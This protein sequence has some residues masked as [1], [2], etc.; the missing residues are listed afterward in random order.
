M[1]RLIYGSSQYKWNFKVRMQKITDF[2]H[3]ELG[4]SMGLIKS[5]R[6][7]LY[8]L[9]FN[10]DFP[11]EEIKSLHN[12]DRIKAMQNCFEHNLNRKN[13]LQMF[14][15][16]VIRYLWFDCGVFAFK[17]SLDLHQ[18]LKEI[19]PANRARLDETMNTLVKNL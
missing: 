2:F 4:M 6:M 8:A 18:H 9:I 3:G 5:E 15:S 13:L 19:T 12:A 14:Q 7:V 17:G 10:F 1:F 16:L 11:K